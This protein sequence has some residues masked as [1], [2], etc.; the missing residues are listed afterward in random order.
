MGRV[1][2]LMIKMLVAIA[3]ANYLGTDNK[4]ILEYSN[5]FVALFLALAAFGLDSFTVRELVRSPENKNNI[6]GTAFSLKLIGGLIIIPLIALTYSFFG[7]SE[8]PYTFILI[9]S[10]IGVF[11]SFNII[12]SYYQSAVQAKFIMQ[13]NVA[14]N[15]VSAALKVVLI[16]LKMPLVA[17]IWALLA[18]A[19]ILTTG[20]IIVYHT[21]KLHIRTWKFDRILG[22]S[23]LVK[24]WPLMFAAIMSAVYM[25]I[26]TLM[27]G[28]MLGKE[29]LGIY[30]T[31]VS[32]SEAWYFI[33]VAIVTSVFPAI[34]NAKMADEKRYQKRLQNL[35]D[36]MVG[37]S[38]SIAIIMTFGSDLVY[39]LFKPEFA[40]GADV[41]KVHIWA[42]IFVF[43]GSASGQYL[44]NEGF[45]QLSLL[46]TAMGAIV[47][48]V[49]NLILLPKMGIIGAAWA[50]LAAYFT[51]TFFIAF[52]PKTS[53]QA[54]LMLKSLFLI[55][56]IQNIR[57]R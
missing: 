15:L 47:N 23:L 51:A 25:K 10:F 39:K 34:I 44:I 1:G 43:L 4:G 28:N 17:F 13:V 57:K 38:L 40:A 50:T 9:V 54:L 2:S 7:S 29:Q 21:Q 16:I 45:T 22:H 30:S 8:T 27:I 42:G 18:D 32:F 56:I 36:L 48:I 11:Q 53:K 55:S 49:L 41:L 20:Y 52:I 26:D 37:L 14:A 33:P 5:S 46:R 24:S 3:V 31:V 6:L 19:V 35:Y 12:D